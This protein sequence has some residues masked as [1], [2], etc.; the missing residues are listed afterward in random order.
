MAARDKDVSYD[1]LHHFSGSSTWDATPLEAALLVKADKL[2]GGEDGWLIIE[3]TALPKKGRNSV[4]VAQQYV[5]MTI[6]GYAFLQS[7]RLKAAGRKKKI[8]GLPM[9]PTMPAIRY[10]ILNCFAQPASRQCP[11]CEKPLIE[12]FLKN[13]SK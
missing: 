8:K 5:L 1:Q 2:F 3:D 6:I 13:M 10:A 4:G 11:H 12:T 9:Q 7:R